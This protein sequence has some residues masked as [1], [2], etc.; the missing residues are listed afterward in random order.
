MLR[1]ILKK[2]PSIP[3][4]AEELHLV[5]GQLVR[6]LR[7]E[8]A[9]HELSWSQLSAMARLEA[10]G[11][12][13]IAALARTEAVKPQSMGATIAPLEKAGFVRRAPHASDGRQVVFALT[14]RGRQVRADG[15]RAKRQWLAG[16]VA[17]K[18]KPAEQRTLRAAL[19]HLQR[20]LES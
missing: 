7:A 2:R 13:T 18:L 3:A 9:S 20:L 15:V 6:R 5:I 1:L 4:L 10:G 12:T 16:A 11:P 17:E 8:G 14:R 19:A